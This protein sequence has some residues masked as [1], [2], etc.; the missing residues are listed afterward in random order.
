MTSLLRRRLTAVACLAALMC[1]PVPAAVA[2]PGP[3]PTP[4]VSTPEADGPEAG[5]PATPAEAEALARAKASGTTVPVDA[6]TTQTSLVAAR[7]DGTLEATITPAPAQ[8]KQNGAWTPVDQDLTRTAGRLAP[9]AGA[10]DASLEAGGGTVLARLADD[11][12]RWFQLAWPTVLPTPVVTGDTAVYR[13]VTPGVDLVARATGTGVATYLVISSASAADADVVANLAYTWSA[14]P[15]LSLNA[16]REGLQVTDGEGDLVFTA[17][18]L[19]M[20][21]SSDLPAS[22]RSDTAAVAT[23]GGDGHRRQLETT[24]TG[25]IINIGVDTAMLDDPGTVFPVAIDP[26]MT[27]GQGAWTMVWNNG[28]TFWGSAEEA[29]V[30]YD[31]WSDNKVSRVYYRFNLASLAGRVIASATLAHRN[32][33]SPNFDCNLATYGPGVQAWTTDPISSA[34][35]WSKQPAAKILQST[36]TVAHGHSGSCPGYSRTEWNVTQGVKGYQ[37]T[38]AMT[39][40]L[41]SANESNRDGWR[42][43]ATIAGQA[44]ALTVVYH[45]TPSTPTRANVAPLY[46]NTPYT[47]AKTLTLSAAIASGDKTDSKLYAKFGVSPYGSGTWTTFNSGYITGA[48]TVNATWKPPKEGAYS[49]RVQACSNSGGGCSGWSGSYAVTADWTAP[50]TPAISGPANPTA[51]QATG[52]TFSSPT[53]DVTGYR[54][55]IT[56]PPGTAVPGTSAGV[57]VNLKPPLGPTTLYGLAVDRAGNQSPTAHLDLKAAGTQTLAHKWLL[58]G[59]GTD[60]GDPA[61]LFNLPLDGSGTGLWTGGVTPPGCPEA[62]GQAFRP[63]GQNVRLLDGSGAGLISTEAF[64][65]ASWIRPES[66][67]LAAGEHFALW[68]T[69]PGKRA[70]MI[71]IKDGHWTASVG[72]ATITGPAAEADTWAYVGIAYDGAGRANLYVDLDDDTYQATGI[73]PAQGTTLAIGWGGT[74]WTG[75]ID[76]VTIHTTYQEQATFRTQRNQCS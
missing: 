73:T 3:A 17:P 47:S 9:R 74:T 37:T 38:G 41:R 33:H 42:R 32:T 65:V 10:V 24:V 59:D 12:G 56:N 34:T 22:A 39:L 70:F 63:G 30:G 4:A 40:M 28:Q 44:P 49:Y 62:Q 60:T 23:T 64:T 69:A 8:V 18:G 36:A 50:A 66:A 11:Q 26:A 46:N 5:V 13:D 27:V 31:G 16:S 51:N 20:W 68:Y 6:S 71:S 58:D 72:D 14:S 54:W 35:T 48:G 43:Y 15:G 45:V 25:H 76:K 55:G 57:T 61:V 21:D 67:D 19:A 1:A 52:Y 7:P 2:D 29:R 75:A 53:S